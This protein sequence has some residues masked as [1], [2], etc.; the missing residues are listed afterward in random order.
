MPR[1][2]IA[3]VHLRYT[4]EEK[5]RLEARAA[6]ARMNMSQ[7]ILAL[8]EQKKI[9]IADELPELCRQ[10]M[11]IGTNVNQIA[12][13]ANTHKSVSEKQLEAVNENLMNVKDLLIKMID[14]IQNS[15]D[16]IKV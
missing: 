7:Y 9:I 10:I 11:K 6:E 5:E 4:L 2:K 8:S 1:N 12:L 15:K 13:V 14:T 3:Q 16:E